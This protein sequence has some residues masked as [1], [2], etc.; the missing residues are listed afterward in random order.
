VKIAASARLGQ[1]VRRAENALRKTLSFSA[2][3]VTE[4]NLKRLD[5][6]S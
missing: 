4:K 1:I 6:A 5:S 2:A 3:F